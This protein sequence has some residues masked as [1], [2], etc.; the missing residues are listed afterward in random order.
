MNRIVFMR[1]I[2]TLV[3]AMLVLAGAGCKAG[4]EPP[5]PSPD[6][7]SAAVPRTGTPAATGDPVIAAAGDIACDPS[8]PRFNGSDPKYCQDE[9]TADVVRNINPDKVIALGDEQYTDGTL[10]EFQKSYARSW[11][12]PDIKDKTKPVVGNHEY[13]TT[14][15]KGYRDFFGNPGGD[16]LAYSYKIGD[17]R[18][19]SL[20]SNCAE[21]AKPGRPGSCSGQAAWMKKTMK[22]SPTKCTIA[23]WHHPRR[24]DV[25]NHYPGASEVAGFEQAFYDSRGDVVLNGHAHSVE[26]SAKVTPAGNSSS[27]GVKHFTI[28]SGGKESYLPWQHSSKPSWNTYRTNSHHAVLQLV[29]HPTSYDY[30]L[31]A[32]D[33]STLFSGTRNCI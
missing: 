12:K 8:S 3:V 32:T 13:H 29:L 11:G 20:N 28:G 5:T 31:K 27:R 30:E 21:L 9:K 26:V 23:A 2:I 6:T 7:A 22:D 33:G 14:N 18:V 4:Q 24:T 16:D 25:A 1:R 19:F 17:W 15:A 10:P